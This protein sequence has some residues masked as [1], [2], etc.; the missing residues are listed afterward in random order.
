MIP[1]PGARPDPFAVLGVSADA[2][3]AEIRAAYR[4]L[5]QLHH[6]DHNAGSAESARRFEEVQD[7]YA[8]IRRLR[9][10]GG[11]APRSGARSGS[12]APPPPTDPA[13]ESQLADLERQVREAHEARERARRAAQEAAQA[14]ASASESTG[15]PSDEELG[16]IHTDDSFSKLLADARSELAARWG[17]G[18]DEAQGHPVARR[19]SDLIDELTAK[20]S[21]EGH[22]GSKPDS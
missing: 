14:A 20:L 1:M 7:A 19:V 18:L 13:V 5:V 12:G 3:D 11:G 2:P 4:R 21:G 17:E 6:P 16:Y 22:R 10:A 8:E 9:A 15:R